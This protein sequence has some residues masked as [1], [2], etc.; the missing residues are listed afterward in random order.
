MRL[1]LIRHGDPDYERDSLTEKGVREAELLSERVKKWN[2]TD[3]YCSP[4]G[5]AKRTAEPTLAKTGRTA[6]ELP[7]LREFLYLVDGKEGKRIPWD[8]YPSEWTNEKP[9]FDEETWHNAYP[10][11]TGEV[12]VRYEELKREL[13]K[14]LKGYGYERDG[15]FYRVRAHSDATAVCFCHFGVSMVILSHLLNIPAPSLLHGCFMA[16][17]SVTVLNTE[18]RFEDEAYFRLQ[19]L[20]D[21]AHLRDGNEPPSQSGYFAPMHIE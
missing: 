6:I 8:Y 4:L 2:V 13:D 18:E 19:V 10:M 5:R 3:F 9:L 12:P 14:L 11:T 17:T 16:P 15:K 7:W 21:T 1:I 20:G